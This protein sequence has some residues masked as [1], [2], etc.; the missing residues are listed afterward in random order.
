MNSKF[1]TPSEENPTLANLLQSPISNISSKGAFLS[2]TS[3]V[4][5]CNE[6]KFMS[7]LLKDSFF[8]SCGLSNESKKIFAKALCYKITNFYINRRLRDIEDI[9]YKT[10]LV[11]YEQ[12]LKEEL[13]ICE[14]FYIGLFMDD[15]VYSVVC[16]NKSALTRLISSAYCLCKG[17]YM[18]TARVTYI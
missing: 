8:E 17:E 16:E 2:S 14:I 18:R 12:L 7:R 15:K 13:S 6:A 10:P 11:L 5:V 4:N 9:L 3:E 1:Q